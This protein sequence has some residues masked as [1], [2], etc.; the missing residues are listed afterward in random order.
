[1]FMFIYVILGKKLEIESHEMS[2]FA[3]IS[4]SQG[5]PSSCRSSVFVTQGRVVGCSGSDS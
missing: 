5:L 2:C 3:D 4:P 1:M